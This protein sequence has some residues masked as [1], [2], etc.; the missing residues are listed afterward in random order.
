M[1][2]IITDTSLRL[3]AAADLR[4]SAARMRRALRSALFDLEHPVGRAV[5]LAIVAIILIAV[6]VSML[7]TVTAIETAWGRWISIAEFCIT[8]V[9][10]FEYLARVYAAESRRRYIFSFF[11][12]VDLLT[13]LP[14]LM[15]GDPGF[16]LRLVRVMRLM[17]L[18]R[19]LSPLWT[20]VCALRDVMQIVLVAMSSILVVVLAAGNLIYLLEPGQF[21]NAF[22]GAWWSLVTMTTV[23]YGDLVPQTIYGK[24]L[25]AALMFIGIAMFAMITGV[26]SQKIATAMRTPGR[27]AECHQAVARTYLYCPHCGSRQGRPRQIG[28]S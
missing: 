12:I 18:A 14:V 4:A 5:N 24:L 17:K 27:C 3:S 1:T 20:F 21:G 10:A 6:V 13:V 19:Y 23:G 7:G 8:V 9:F 15:M 11:G 22:Q 25:A 26:V 16:A 2:T 28:A